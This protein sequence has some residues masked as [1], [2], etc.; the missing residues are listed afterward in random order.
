MRP[1]LRTC[2]CAIAVF[3]SMHTV[4]ADEPA[5]HPVELRPAAEYR[6]ELEA[7]LADGQPAEGAN[8]WD[9]M[10][11]AIRAMRIVQDWDS[12]F[13]EAHP[14]APS[15]SIPSFAADEIRFGAF[16][17]GAW[18]VGGEYLDRM[19]R[20]GVWA[21]LDR[22]GEAPRRVP[23]FLWEN[24]EGAAGM[25]AVQLEVNRIM[26]LLSKTPSAMRIA[27][28]GKQDDHVVAMVRRGCVVAEVTG[29]CRDSVTWMKAP[30]A[31]VLV[32]REICQENMEEPYGA[33]LLARVDA[34]L[35]R[36]DPFPSARRWIEAVP[37]VERFHAATDPEGYRAATGDPAQVIP[38]VDA[39]AA[40]AIAQ[41]DKPLAERERPGAGY[42]DRVFATMMATRDM[43]DDLNVRIAL[44]PLGERIAGSIEQVMDSGIYAQTMVAGTRAVIAVE[45]Y[46][47]AHGQYPETL[48]AVVPAFLPAVPVDPMTGN[49]LL[50]TRIENDPHLREYLV[51]STGID[52]IDNGGRA[53]E[54]DS[55]PNPVGIAKGFD[56]IVNQP[57]RALD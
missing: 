56:F 50:Y 19:D 44:I 47:I 33:N 25:S 2:A 51:Y 36:I 53:P 1:L 7:L 57:R 31:C 14:D 23:P 24:D 3:A 39:V 21:A 13:I 49:P 46:R 55:Y 42:M 9:E 26:P 4:A 43:G 15:L 12:Q 34:E 11:A 40:H 30:L 16:D 48:A 32:C 5:P 29:S 6:A 10:F 52:G 18:K 17:A 22:A 45:R 41:L 28:H 20:E 35:S 27:H 8:A 38:L 37:V 54:G